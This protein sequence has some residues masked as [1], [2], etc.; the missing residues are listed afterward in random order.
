MSNQANRIGGGRRDLSGPW[1][2]GFA[3]STPS[4]PNI[5]PPPN[6]SPNYRGDLN[7]PRNRCA[8]IP[9]AENC[10]TWWTN[11]PADCSYEMLF[12]SIR[13]VGAVSHAVINPP[14]GIHGTSA[15]KIEFFERASVDRLLSQAANG[16]IRGHIRVGGRIPHISLNRVKVA[17]HSNEVPVEYG[18]NGRG[19]RVLQVIGDPQIVNPD[20]LKALLADSRHRVIYGLECIRDGPGPDGLHCVEFRFASYVVQALRARNVFVTQKHSSQ[21]SDQEK[22]LWGG[23][24]CTFARDP[25]E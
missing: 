14:V 13:H 5:A 20:K 23:V 25:C 11:L 1:R 10:A 9:D 22:A 8:D 2:P 17:A 18:N 24:V 12:N 3:P 15:A 19:T 4:A 16:H 7:N 6:T 21:L